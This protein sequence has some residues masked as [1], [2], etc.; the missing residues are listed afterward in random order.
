VIA[1]SPVVAPRYL[2]LLASEQRAAPSRV[3]AY[4]SGAHAHLQ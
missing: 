3:P 1:L 2:P 4:Q